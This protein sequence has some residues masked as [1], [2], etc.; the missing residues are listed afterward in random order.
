MDNH[1]QDSPPLVAI[2][3]RDLYGAWMLESWMVAA[4]EHDR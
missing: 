1:N 3:E 2:A 4:Q